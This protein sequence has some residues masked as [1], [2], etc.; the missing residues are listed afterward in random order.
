MEETSS[1]NNFSRVTRSN[2]C[3]ICGK[4]DWCLIAKWGGVLC[5]RVE[6][7]KAGKS[8]GWWH[9][10]GADHGPVRFIPRREPPP[11]DAAAVMSRFHVRTTPTMQAQLAE[12]LGVSTASVSVLA[13]CWAEEH[14]AWAFPMRDGS[15]NVIGIRLRNDEGQKWAVK[16]SR[17]GIFIPDTTHQDLAMICEGPTDTAAAL[18]L[19]YYAIGRPSCQGGTLET[20]AWLASKFI[21]RIVIVADND[22]PGYAGAEKFGMESGC[23]WKLWTPIQKDI[24][25]FVCAGGT[26]LDIEH[27]LRHL[28]WTRPKST[29]R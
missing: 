1:M 4:P 26:R 14:R 10:P 22:G 15:G 5:M 20:S 7:S 28:E 3:P 18:T 8:G 19:G 27:D 2:P 11:L 29:R 17:Q 16:G 13:A 23:E 25:A 21:R 12:S 24:R 6:S 9:K